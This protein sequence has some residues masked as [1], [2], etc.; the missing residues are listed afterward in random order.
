MTNTW[1]SST[2]QVNG[3]NL[4]GKWTEKDE[5]SLARQFMPAEN[6]R[7]CSQLPHLTD[8]TSDTELRECLGRRGAAWLSNQATKPHNKPTIQICSWLSQIYGCSCSTCKQACQN[9]NHYTHQEMLL[10]HF[11]QVCTLDDWVIFKKMC[12]YVFIQFNFFFIMSEN[13]LSSTKDNTTKL[14]H[15]LYNKLWAYPEWLH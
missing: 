14:Y 3:Q 7:P 5:Q 4:L 13:N 6:T 2:S 1:S 15:R 8:F 10:N 11:S 12:L 9:W